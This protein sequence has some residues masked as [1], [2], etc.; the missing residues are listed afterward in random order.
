MKKAFRTLISN[1][2]DLQQCSSILR[3]CPQIA[4]DIEAMKGDD[5]MGEVSLIQFAGLGRETLMYGEKPK[6]YLVD[7]LA[8]K[9]DEVSEQLGPL[10]ESPTSLKLFYDSRGDSKVLSEQFGIEIPNSHKIDIQLM[11]AADRWTKWGC[12]HR[13]TLDKALEDIGIPLSSAS[14]KEQMVSGNDIWKDRPLT[15]ELLDYAASGVE[16]L[17]ALWRSKSSYHE[18]ALRLGARHAN[19]QTDE[20][21]TVKKEWL[22][23]IVG[24][25]GVCTN[26][27]QPGH[28]PKAC[29]LVKTCSYCGMSGHREESCF[30][31]P[32]QKQ[33][34]TCTYCNAIGHT[35]E[36][37]YA[38]GKVLICAHCGEKGHILKFCRHRNPCEKCGKFGHTAKQCRNPPKVNKPELFDGSKARNA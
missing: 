11:V 32:G 34:L 23:E 35:E 31:R 20:V 21:N 12:P 30:K 15:E 7:A 19:I 3:S 37:C 10:L 24:P 28:E 27:N 22:R 17:F 36:H 13:L 33:V 6:I 9:N 5:T 29:Q 8:M 38:K 2:S 18:T 25:P 14:V 16:N 1:K 26:C 4:I